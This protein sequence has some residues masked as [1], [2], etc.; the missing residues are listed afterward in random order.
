ML[1]REVQVLA[2]DISDN[3]VLAVELLGIS[4]NEE[5]KGL[6]L[7]LMDA[8]SLSWLI[9]LVADMSKKV[10]FKKNQVY[11]GF[12]SSGGSKSQEEQSNFCS[13]NSPVNSMCQKYSNALAL[14]CSP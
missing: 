9:A 6:F 2:R 5:F 12:H 14:N 11:F 1:E 4:V 10:N 3:E 7:P 8:V 13:T